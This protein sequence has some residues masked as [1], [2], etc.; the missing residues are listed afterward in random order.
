MASDERQ[1]NIDLVINQGQDPETND[2][3]SRKSNKPKILEMEPR[4]QVKVLSSDYC[5]ISK[6]ENII[7]IEF[8]RHEIIY[9]NNPQDFADN[10]FVKLDGVK[11]VPKQDQLIAIKNHLQCDEFIEL[12]ND[13]NLV[14]NHDNELYRMLKRPFIMR[15][16]GWVIFA[17]L[18]MSACGVFVAGVHTELSRN[19]STSKAEPNYKNNFS[20]PFFI[21]TVFLAVMALYV[22][23][24]C[25][26]SKILREYEIQKFKNSIYTKSVVEIV[27][28]FNEDHVNKR[29]YIDVAPNLEY[30]HVNFN[31]NNRLKLNRIIN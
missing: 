26:G 30:I 17:L 28:T 5:T 16:C 7:Q 1:I 29:I 22:L 18:I 31:K 20:V 15:T 11:Y 24:S 4:G 3:K 27:N 13:L 6:T 14:I 23:W 25:I 10:V 19:D 21:I 8:E 2:V 9:L 12:V